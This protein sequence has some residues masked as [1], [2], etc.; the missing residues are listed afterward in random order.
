MCEQTGCE[1]CIV[2]GPH[3]N[4]MHRVSRIDEA[5][6]ARYLYLNDIVCGPLLER[7][8]KLNSYLEELT[9]LSDELRY[10]KSGVEKMSK[11][12]FA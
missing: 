8:D 2:Y 4:Q 1:S 6:Q 10:V 9:V 5:F 11:M 3:N 12:E 7:R